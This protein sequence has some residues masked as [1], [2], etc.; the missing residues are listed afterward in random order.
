MLPLFCKHFSAMV[1]GFVQ[2]VDWPIKAIKAMCRFCSRQW[3]LALQTRNYTYQQS[4]ISK[5]FWRKVIWVGLKYQSA[6]KAIS[7]GVCFHRNCQIYLLSAQI[8]INSLQGASKFGSPKISGLWISECANHSKLFWATVC[9]KCGLDDQGDQSHGRFLNLWSWI[10][11][12]TVPPVPLGKCTLFVFVKLTILNIRLHTSGGNM[13]KIL[14][15]LMSWS[16]HLF[17]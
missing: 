16:K 2:N 5:E 12:L 10:R 8:S 13:A 15:S 14:P 7:F 17:H 3:F 1:D 4:H 6:F 9:A 11:T